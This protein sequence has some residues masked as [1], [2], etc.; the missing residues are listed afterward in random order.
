M[1]PWARAPENPLTDPKEGRLTRQVAESGG[2]PDAAQLGANGWTRPTA[3]TH[4]PKFTAQKCPFTLLCLALKSSL[5]DKPPRC[6]QL[7]ER[8]DDALEIVEQTE[9]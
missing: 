1:V 6:L 7:A 4:R 2:H 5:D 9:V 8:A 3:E